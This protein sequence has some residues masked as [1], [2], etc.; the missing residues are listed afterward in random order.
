M[1]SVRTVV[2]KGKEQMMHEVRLD[3]MQ[4]S[5]E[6]RKPPGCVPSGAVIASCYIPSASYHRYKVR[7]GDIVNCFVL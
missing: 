5:T 1:E 4:A 7:K 6:D 2:K 3:V